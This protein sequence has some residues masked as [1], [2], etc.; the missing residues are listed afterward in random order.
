MLSAAPNA[1]AQAE[2]TAAPKH[3]TKMGYLNCHVAS[4]WGFIFGSSR[5]LECV[6]TPAASGLERWETLVPSAAS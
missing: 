5:K 2:A 4:G 3:T 1:F 6:H